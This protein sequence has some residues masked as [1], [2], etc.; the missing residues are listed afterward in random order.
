MA[1]L[2]RAHL[3]TCTRIGQWSHYRRNNEAIAA[4]G[5]AIGVGL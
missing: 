1:V 3:V 2:Q 5:A 4:L